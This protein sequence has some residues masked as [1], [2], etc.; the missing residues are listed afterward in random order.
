MATA[1]SAIRYRVQYS[2]SVPPVAT[3]HRVMSVASTS[4]VAARNLFADMASYG[5][6]RSDQNAYT[7]ARPR[8]DSARGRTAGRI[9]VELRHRTAKTATTALL[10]RAG[11]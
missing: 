5:R 10:T 9:P 6:A 7:A 4:R 2:L 1:M 8:P 11:E 3:H